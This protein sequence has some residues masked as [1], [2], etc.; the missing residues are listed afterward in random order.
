MPTIWRQRFGTMKTTIVIIGLC[1]AIMGHAL[2]QTNQIVAPIDTNT[3]IWALPMVAKPKP[4]VRPNEITTRAGT[5]YK[6]IKIERV[7]P[8]G[9][10]VRY[11]MAGGGLG[12][13]K[14]TFDK[15]P[16]DLQKKYNYDPQQAA[17]FE[18]KQQQAELELRQQLEINSRIATESEN[19]RIDEGILAYKNRQQQKLDE[20]LA[21]AKQKAAEAQQRT[22]TEQWQAQYELAQAREAPRQA[23]DD[24]DEI[25][26]KLRRSGMIIGGPLD[27][28]LMP[29]SKGGMVIGGPLNGTMLPGSKGGM[30]IGGPLDGT[31]MP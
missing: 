1:V 17:T 29:D 8:S 6:N 14:I 3:P 5:V 31:L 26:S 12:I 2:A 10:T 20:Q 28:T 9:L 21:Q 18:I 24:L 30:I 11:S 27:G 4:L 7:D 25:S 16:D 15:L 23:Q 13:T 19:K 22:E